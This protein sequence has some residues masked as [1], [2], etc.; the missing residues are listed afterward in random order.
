MTESETAG[1]SLAQ[2]AQLFDAG[3]YVVAAAF[4]DGAPTLALA[5]GVVLI[6]RASCRERV[7][8]CV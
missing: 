3:A 4:V 5:D 2:H 7:Y 1:S 8:L 6:G